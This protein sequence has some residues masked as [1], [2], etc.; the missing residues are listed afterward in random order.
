ME[1]ETEDFG[2]DHANLT[3]NS[4]GFLWQGAARMEAKHDTMTTGK[5]WL[6]PT[7]AA[8]FP[9]HPKGLFLPS[10]ND[11]NDSPTL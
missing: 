4:G 2:R 6:T 8:T 3:G 11:G 9:G 5:A 1:I 7:S 10:L